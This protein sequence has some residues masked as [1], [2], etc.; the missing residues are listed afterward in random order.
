MANGPNVGNAYIQIIPSM[1]GAQKSIS[2]QFGSI[3][4]SEGPA[5][6]NLLGEGMMSGI[7][8]KLGAIG[9]LM[10]KILP[11]ASVA[12][13]GKALFDI[14][15]EFDEMT[16]TIIV[17]TGATGKALEEL[18]NSAKSIAT[19]APTS[20]AEAGDI[21]QDLNTRLGLTGDTLTQVGTQIAQVGD[22]TGQAFDTESFAGAMSAWGASADEM[23]GHLDTLFAISQS[24]GIG[25][26]ELT[27]ITE[28][29]APQM[30]ALGYS[31]EETAAMAG[32]LDKAGLDASGTMSKMSKALTTLAKDGEEPAEA[33]TRITE[34]IQGYIEKGDEAAAISA[35]SD[36]FGTRGATQ[37]V[38]AVQS[39]SMSI[40]EF[41]KAMSDS[42][43]IIGETEGRTMSFGERVTILKNQ[44]KELLEP[45]GSAVFAGLSTAMTAVTDA[46]GKFVDGPGQT[47]AAVFREIVGI[48]QNVAESFTEAFGKATGITSVSTAASK[49]GSV[50]RTVGSVLKPVASLF[51]SLLRTVLP[52]LAKLV[53]TTLGTAFR[54]LGKA[55]DVGKSALDRIKSAIN[56]VKSAFE[57]FKRII[58]APFR[59][60]SGL[61]IPHISV[62]GG[63]APWGIGGLGVK[64]S[65]SVTWAAKGM[66]LDK[67]TLIGAGEAGREGI[68][69]LEGGAMRPFAEAIAKEMGGSAGNTFNITLNANGVES[70]EA[71][72]QRFTRELKRQVRMGAI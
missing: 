42:A 43:G 6:G 5:A 24:T 29:A 66:I 53:G 58:T 44:F 39:G 54:A 47:I 67:A 21:V 1:E 13:V 63:K 37:F 57:T 16:D 27:G 38:A 7:G 4:G 26:N 11:A 51:G 49:L 32:L 69:P 31:F 68:I 55:I 45:M 8:G 18:E 17:G 12:A 35:A 28:S 41:A 64:P 61:K 52:P 70:P 2:Q 25:I 3:M 40:E 50:F 56:T 72:A 23:S 9:G 14:G 10:K 15:S 30:S 65:F 22:L 19:T 33:M 71:Y 48:A 46:F 20:F 60:L 36:L 59:F 62:S 34:E